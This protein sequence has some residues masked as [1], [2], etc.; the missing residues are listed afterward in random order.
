M[1]LLYF[2]LSCSELDTYIISIRVFFNRPPVGKIMAK[3]V[4]Q[5]QRHQKNLLPPN[6]FSEHTK[7]IR[8]LHQSSRNRSHIGSIILR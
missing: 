6:F 3:T 5:T 2:K 7:I 1:I 8:D 4:Y